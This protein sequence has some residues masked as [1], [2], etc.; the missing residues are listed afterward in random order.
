[1]EAGRATGYKA[2]LITLE[3]GSR[4]I[5]LGENDV[6]QLKEAFDTPAK[7]FYVFMQLERQS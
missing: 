4:G 3:V 2:S 7:E 1:M 6:I 5:I